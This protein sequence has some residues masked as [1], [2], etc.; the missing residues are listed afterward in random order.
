MRF[1]FYGRVSTE[2]Q[3]DP[4]ASKSWQLSRARSLIEPAGGRVVEEFFDVGLSRSLPWKRR[5]DAQRLLDAIRNP[6]RGFEAVVIGEPQ[7]AFYGSQFSMTFPIFIHYGVGLWVPEIGGAIDPGS[8]AHDLVM[9][10][11]FG[12][13]NG[14]RTVSRSG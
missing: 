8:D 6:L 14:E 12:M 1:D 2:D 9:S 7:G 10:L 13:S 3:Q 4:Q 5:P 11:Y